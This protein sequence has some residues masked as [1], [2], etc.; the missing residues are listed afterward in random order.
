MT[1]L[2][3]ILPETPKDSAAVDDL[4]EAAF[5]PGR[6]AKAAER[7]REGNRHLEGI[8]VIARQGRAVVGCARM[9]PVRVGATPAVLL[10]PFAVADSMRNRGLGQALA[11]AACDRAREA[12]HALVILVGDAP[13]FERVGFR[14]V[15]PAAVRLPGPVDL[16]R[17]LVREL[18]PGAAEG[19]A[20]LVAAP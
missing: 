11:A 6:Y 16:R 2:P 1:D 5:G 7:L 13:F 8:S 3:P 20:G 18:K 14:P 9:W 17:V 19:L 10:G 12:G 15:D 4:I